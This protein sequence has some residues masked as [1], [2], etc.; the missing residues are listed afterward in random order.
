MCAVRSGCLR[1]WRRFEG[2]GRITMHGHVRHDAEHRA[3]RYVHQQHAHDGD[4][5]AASHDAATGAV[6]ST[7]MLVCSI[8]QHLVRG[9][10]GTIRRMAHELGMHREQ[11][12]NQQNGQK[13]WIGFEYHEPCSQTRNGEPTSRF[14]LGPLE[15]SRPRAAGSSGTLYHKVSTSRDRASKYDVRIIHALD[16]PTLSNCSVRDRRDHCQGL[17][18]IGCLLTPM[19]ENARDTGRP[20]SV[21][22]DCLTSCVI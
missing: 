21:Q 17:R 3:T 9:R 4:L 1:S 13:S 10:L 19:T 2:T 6:A 11:R 12:R 20:H 7:V 15:V 18:R 16:L 14:R 22:I 5:R 8:A